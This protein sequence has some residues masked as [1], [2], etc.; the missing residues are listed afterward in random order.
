MNETRKK[1]TLKLAALAGELMMKNGAE[2]SRV[3]DTIERIC[4][5]CGVDHVEVFAVPSGVFVSI[6]PDEEDGEVLT[7]IR[8]LHNWTTNLK[9]VD[10]INQFS[11]TFAATGMSVEEGLAELDRIDR[12]PPFPMPLSLFGAALAAGMFGAIYSGHVKAALITAVIA[13]FCELFYRFL[14]RLDMNYYIKG[15]GC[16]AFA[17]VLAICCESM[18]LLSGIGA[19]VI[20][21][22]MLYTPGAAITNSIRDLLGGDTLSGVTRLADAILIALTLATGVGVVLKLWTLAGTQAAA[23]PA[24]IP[25]A[26]TLLLGTLSVPGFSILF[27]VPARCML[28]ATVTGGAGWIIY[29]LCF[30]NGQS[31]AASVFLG[32]VMVGG[33][34]RIFAKMMK[35]PATAFVIAGIIP[36][37]PGALTFYSMQAF[38]AGSIETGLELTVRTIAS[39]GAIAL[40]LLA[41]GAATQLVHKIHHTLLKPVAAQHKGDSGPS[42]TLEDD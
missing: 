9:K 14:S 40:G 7:Y 39:A 3:E 1:Q 38:F 10:N 35:A 16:C 41:V 13:V 4:S 2:V 42:G 27:Q 12:Q 34:A 8:R 21:V 20:G 19:V 24:P 23:A 29:Q 22:L 31:S 28:P 15:M 18:S 17:T 37:V 30:A 33:F 25:L 26:V 6:E 5:A 32:A 11:H 36:L